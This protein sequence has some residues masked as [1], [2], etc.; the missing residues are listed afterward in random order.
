MEITFCPYC[1][2]NDIEEFA[3][4]DYWCDECLTW[5]SKADFKDEVIMEIEEDFVYK[6]IKNF[7]QT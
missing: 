1:E 5:F 2:S 6:R 3:M 4:Q 7:A